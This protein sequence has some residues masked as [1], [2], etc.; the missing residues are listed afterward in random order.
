MADQFPDVVAAIEDI[1][2][3]TIGFNLEDMSA[4]EQNS[5]TANPI[6]QLLYTGGDFE[7]TTGERVDTEEPF[8]TIRIGFRQNTP[9]QSRLDQREWIKKCKDN[10]TAKIL[11]D[12][13]ANV[14]VR[15]LL[16]DPYEIDYDGT[17]SDI[18]YQIR[19]GFR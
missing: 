10:L 7:D 16:H 4:I 19:V 3:N 13:Y 14:D 12:N 17:Y 1:L 6:A 15:R 9:S 8:F 11:N 5:W 2:E 18:L